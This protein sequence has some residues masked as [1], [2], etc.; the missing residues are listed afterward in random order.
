MQLKSLGGFAARGHDPQ[1]KKLLMSDQSL[2]VLQWAPQ[3]TG[4]A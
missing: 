1:T 3:L 2:L 4:R